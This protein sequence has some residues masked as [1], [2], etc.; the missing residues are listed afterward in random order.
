MKGPLPYPEEDN[1]AIHGAYC[2][3]PDLLLLQSE[4]VTHGELRGLH[5][6]LRPF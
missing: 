3:T 4:I 1:A 5:F 2:C 6:T